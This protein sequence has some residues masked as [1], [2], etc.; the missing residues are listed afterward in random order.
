MKNRSNKFVMFT[1]LVGIAFSIVL[2]QP[3]MA[4]AVQ[5]RE[6]NLIEIEE[7]ASEPT[8]TATQTP[9]QAPTPAPTPSATPEPTPVPTPVVTPTPEPT[10][11][12]AMYEF[13]GYEISQD[14][15]EYFC[16]GVYAEAGNQDY[17]GQVSTAAVIL[18]RLIDTG[19]FKNVNS[20][21]EVLGN[22]FSSVINGKVTICGAPIT[23]QDVSEETIEAVKS[24]INGED[25]TEGRLW[26]IAEATGNDPEEYA[27]GGALYF[28]NPDRTS[29]EQLAYRANIK[30]RYQLQNHIFYKVWDL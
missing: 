23:F 2:F 14:E 4:Q 25:P 8:P 17:E 29:P 3:Y 24:A 30:V 1:I 13:E 7:Q 12:P 11:E 9:E 10:A 16:M 6:N 21:Y 26:E 5:V 18:N 15:F 28:Y 20:I 22:G 19:D 27:S